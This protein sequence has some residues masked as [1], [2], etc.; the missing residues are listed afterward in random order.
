[1][2]AA[3]HRRDGRPRRGQRPGLRQQQRGRPLSGHGAAARRRSRSGLGRGKR[4]AMLLGRLRLA[5]LVSAATGC[6]SAPPGLEAPIRT[7]LLFVGNN[8]YQVNL[9]ALGQREALDEGELCLYAIRARSRLHL[10]WAGHPRHV[11]QAR[12]AARLRHRLCDRRPRSPRTGRCWRCRPTARR[13]GWRRRCA[14][15]SGRRR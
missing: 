12:P 1:M 13:C 3:G 6:G 15:G 10:L 9:F 11:R 5:A 4:L 8:R 2:I 7:P 14:T